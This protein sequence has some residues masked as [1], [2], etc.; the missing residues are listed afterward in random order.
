MR[1]STLIRY[2]CIELGNTSKFKKNKHFVWYVEICHIICNVL[3]YIDNLCFHKETS[4]DRMSFIFIWCY[5]FTEHA[6]HR[7][8]FNHHSPL[9]DGSFMQHYATDSWQVIKSSVGAFVL[10]IRIMAVDIMLSLYT[11]NRCL[12]RL[13]SKIFT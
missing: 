2:G 12:G 11:S 7:G 5:P 6:Y 9:I 1:Y 4:S 10:V 8:I 13:W 3:V